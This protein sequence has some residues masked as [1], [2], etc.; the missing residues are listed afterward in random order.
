MRSAAE[1]QDFEVVASVPLPNAIAALVVDQQLV[2]TR[3]RRKG[4]LY[5][6]GCRSKN[7][8]CSHVPLMPL[9]AHQHPDVH[10]RFPR[11]D[12]L[13]WSRI[14]AEAHISN[15]IIYQG[16][17]PPCSSP[18]CDGRLRC[19]CPELLSVGIL[20]NLPGQKSL[21]PA[22]LHV[23]S[24]QTDQAEAEQITIDA[25]LLGPGKPSRGT[26]DRWHLGAGT[27][28]PSGQRNFGLPRTLESAEYRSTVTPGRS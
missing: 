16:P 28:I 14:V 11:P 25:L 2:I 1:E 3:H 7:G 4:G 27:R 21:M 8:E 17:P 6:S 5:L 15:G 9:W 13:Q 10:K 23:Y 19:S 20:C 18:F 26:S 24:P 12:G 22:S